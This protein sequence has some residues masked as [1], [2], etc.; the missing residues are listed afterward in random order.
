MIDIILIKLLLSKDLFNKFSKVI[1]LDFYKNNN[2]EV[3]RILSSL[4]QLH[5]KVS[6][7][8]TVQDLVMF[9]YASYPAIKNDEKVLYNTIFDQIEKA[10]VNQEV[11]VEYLEKHRQQ[12]LATEIAMKALDV[13]RG[14][15]DLSEITT[16]LNEQLPIEEPTEEVF[17]SDDLEVLADEIQLDGGLRWRLETMNRMLGPLRKGDFGFIF[18]RPETGGTTFL[19]SELTYMAEQVAQ[20]DEG[21][22]LWIN[23]EQMGN[24]VMLRIYSAVFGVSDRELFTNLDFYKDE[25]NKRIRGK[26]KVFDDALVTKQKIESLCKTWN[27]SAVVIDQID[28]LKGF[29]NNERDDLRLGTIYI[30]AREM[31]KQYCPWIGVCQADSTAEGKK[32]LTMDMV[33]NAKTAKQA[34]ADWILGIGKTHTDGEEYTRFLSVCKNKLLGDEKTMPELRHGKVPVII[35]PDIA[36]YDDAMKWS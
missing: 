22:V 8:I 11:A 20:R 13:S 32:W 17:V 10:E 16:L 6:T 4:F 2:R 21:P 3:F 36:R 19:A 23:N 15:G 7:D 27:P 31:A 14:K 26:I 5:E 1:N 34:E 29:P 30:W 28:K 24:V 18:K 33:A 25:Y 9:F 35:H 12:I